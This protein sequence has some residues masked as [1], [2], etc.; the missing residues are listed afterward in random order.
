MFDERNVGAPTFLV[1]VLELV[2]AF[3]ASR[4]RRASMAAAV[5]SVTDLWYAA[6]TKTNG[7]KPP[8]FKAG[9][10]REAWGLT[11]YRRTRTNLYTER[12]RGRVCSRV[13]R[14][15]L[16]YRSKGFRFSHSRSHILCVFIAGQGDPDSV[17]QGSSQKILSDAVPC[18]LRLWVSRFFLPNGCHPTGDRRSSRAP[19]TG[20]CF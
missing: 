17:N 19:L 7:G 16:N 2:P 8:H 11:G 6:T 15:G 13:L 5:L 14:Q 12:C 4:R 9:P 18:A 1:E 3:A 10:G 20:F